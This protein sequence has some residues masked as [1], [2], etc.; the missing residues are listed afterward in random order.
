MKKL[1]EFPHKHKEDGFGGASPRTGGKDARFLVVTS[2]PQERKREVGRPQERR[3]HPRFRCEARAEVRL[4]GSSAVLWGI[5]TDISEGGCYIELPSPLPKD[6]T[7]HLKLTL[8]D[9]TIVAQ[10]KVSASHP[11]FG[12]GLTIT[13]CSPEERQKLQS[14]LTRIDQAGPLFVRGAVPPRAR[15]GFQPFPDSAAAPQGDSLTPPKFRIPPQA[16]H[17]VLEKII[18]QTTRQGMLSFSDL[19]V[20]LEAA[21]EK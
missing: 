11:M 18:Q 17:S 12:M 13:S 7:V 3:R 6:Q 10:A 20:I 14:V 4:P 9:C 2:E 21:Q 19:L 8:L 16:A 15:A 5:A 1:E